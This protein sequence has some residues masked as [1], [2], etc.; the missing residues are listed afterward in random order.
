MMN[1]LTAAP[2]L[3]QANHRAREGAKGE[4]SSG[5]DVEGWELIMNS[6]IGLSQYR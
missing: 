2:Q 1:E 5:K 6:T 3:E 4:D